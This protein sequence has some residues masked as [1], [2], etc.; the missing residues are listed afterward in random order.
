MDR[1]DPL[2]PMD[3]NEPALASESTDPADRALM[4]DSTETAERAE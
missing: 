3:S 2:D 4:K 1:T